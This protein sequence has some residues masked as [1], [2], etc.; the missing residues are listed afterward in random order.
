MKSNDIND[1][2]AIN[3][4]NDING[5]NDTNSPV[6]KP[7]QPLRRDKEELQSDTQFSRR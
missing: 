2:N 3:D 4:F 5:S 7:K 1:I 6:I